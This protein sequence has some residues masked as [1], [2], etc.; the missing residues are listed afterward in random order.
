MENDVVSV[1]KVQ[2][3]S[4]KPSQETLDNLRIGQLVKLE[5]GGTPEIAQQTLACLTNTLA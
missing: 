5:S 2:V 3:E 1:R 4:R